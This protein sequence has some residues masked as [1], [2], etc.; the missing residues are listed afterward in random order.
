[1]AKKINVDNLKLAYSDGRVVDSNET[2]RFVQKLE[3]MSKKYGGVTPED[4]LTIFI[5]ENGLKNGA[6]LLDQKSKADTDESGG[7]A[8]G[9]IQFVPSTAKGLGLDQDK[10]SEMTATEQLDFVDKY[11]K[12]LGDPKNI[13]SFQ[14]LYLGTFY[15]KALGEGDDFVIAKEGRRAY[16]ANANIDTKFGDGDGVLTKGDFLGYAN[17]DISSMTGDVLQEVS[18]EEYDRGYPEPN[19]VFINSENV[20]VKSGKNK[21]KYKTVYTLPDGSRKA[22]VNPSPTTI[23]TIA[24]DQ[25]LATKGGK[26]YKLDRE[27]GFQEKALSNDNIYNSKLKELE[28]KAK[29]GDLTPRELRVAQN[30]YDV[31]QSELD[32]KIKGRDEGF[33]E[34]APKIGV[35]NIKGLRREKAALERRFSAN[36]LLPEVRNRFKAEGEK[37]KNDL[38]KLREESLDFNKSEDELIQAKKNLAIAE[39]EYDTFEDGREDFAKKLESYDYLSSSKIKDGNR[40]ESKNLIQE[41]AGAGLGDL[42]S[43]MSKEL[44]SFLSKDVETDVALQEEKVQDKPDLATQD[45][46]RGGGT[47]TSTSQQVKVGTRSDNQV[48]DSDLG[49]TS[50]EQDILDA[51]KVVDTDA[52]QQQID[53]NNE[54]LAEMKAQKPIDDSIVQGQDDT[55]ENVLGYG[56]DIAR[57][58]VGLSGATEK[59]PEYERGAAFNEYLDTQRRFKDQ[60]LTALEES[61]RKQRG[62]RAYGF[63]VAN[64]RSMGQGAGATLAAM[65][66]AAGR[67]Q[68]RYA[69][70]GLEDAALKRQ[71]RADFARAALTDEQINRQQFEDKFKVSMANKEAG[72]GLVRDAYTNLNERVAFNKAYGKGSQHYAYQDEL[73]KSMKTNRELLKRG[74]ENRTKQGVKALE[75]SNIELQKRIDKANV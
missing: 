57:G 74:A 6:I 67:L 41:Y 5:K 53:L 13:K 44:N 73:M 19:E 22:V 72:A 69:E 45:I 40:F 27:S 20:L 32:D 18:Q 56:S 52:L 29:S 24:G 11:Y 68:D 21:G 62:E 54:A 7:K 3:K 59:L 75:E 9:L 46:N 28:D 10:L 31:R 8:K 2:R 48:V 33:F 34:D 43:E 71:G 38:N 35:R 70:V 61:V 1:M 58:I 47:G 15:P 51:K 16:T 64:I 37:R 63:D 26:N 14:D 42:V 49:L 23:K 65:G 12:D 55:L 60:G 4:F 50:E 66:G 39:S 36:I 30:I 17:Q 25:Y